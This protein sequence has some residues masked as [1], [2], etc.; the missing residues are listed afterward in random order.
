MTDGFQPKWASPPGDTINEIMRR[1]EISADQFS[2]SLGLSGKH[3]SELLTGKVAIDS[4][5][6]HRLEQV[7]GVSASF[8]L[9]RESQYREDLARQTQTREEEIKNAWLRQFPLRDMIQFGWM[10]AASNI[11]GRVAALLQFFGVQTIAAWHERYRGLQD[12]VAFRTSGS[13]ESQPGAVA[14]WLRQG[15]LIASK[16]DCSQWDAKRFRAVLP[17]IRKL[18]RKKRPEL[19]VSELVEL[20]ASCGVAVAITPAPEGCRAS[21]ATRFITPIK[22]LLMLS[23][24]HKTDDHFW[25]TF[26]HE[27]GHLLLHASNALFVEDANLLTTEEEEEANK[28]AMDVLVPPDRQQEMMRLPKNWKK[29]V[30]FAHDI[31]ISHGIVVGQLQHHKCIERKDLNR[32]K[33]RYNWV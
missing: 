27:A 20:C 10:K 11:D 7:V 6:A 13:F 25:F 26:F 22:A 18:T 5:L 17:K 14:T 15:E 32:L 8:W 16:I 1:K 33:V 12:A 24:R 19:F 28:F 2:K 31:G 23:Y 30:E 29:V 3:G 4:K 9:V 21:G